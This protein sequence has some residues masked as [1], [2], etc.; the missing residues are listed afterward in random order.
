MK[1]ECRYCGEE[2]SRGPH[3][4]TPNWHNQQFCSRTCA[5]HANHEAKG[6]V[7]VTAYLDA[8]PLNRAV[9]EMFTKL[10]LPHVGAQRTFWR[11]GG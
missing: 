8:Y 4:S 6:T 2:F 10:K 3:L 7:R 1:K 11:E 5:A 9:V